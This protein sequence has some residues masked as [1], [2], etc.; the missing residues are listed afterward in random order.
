MK[1]DKSTPRSLPTTILNGKTYFVDKRLNQ[2]RNV[3]NPHDFINIL[4]ADLVVFTGGAKEV[5][6]HDRNNTT[7]QR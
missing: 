6:K 5:K 4:D 2:L 1:E 3:E 7:I